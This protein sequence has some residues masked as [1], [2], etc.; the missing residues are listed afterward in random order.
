MN[1]ANGY[2][3]VACQGYDHSLWYAQAPIQGPNSACG[4]TGGLPCFT[5]FTSNSGTFTSGPALVLLNGTLYNYAVG[6][7]HKIWY[8]VWNQPVWYSTGWADGGCVD[9][10]AGCHPAAQSI[11]GGSFGVMAIPSPDGHIWYRV[12]N[13]SGWSAG[14]D[15]G[16]PPA[17]VMDGVGVALG[18]RGEFT[19]YCALYSST[20]GPQAYA[21]HDV[22]TGLAG[23][24]FYGF[25][26]SP[27]T[28]VGAG[29]LGSTEAGINT[30]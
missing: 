9:T 25:S 7:D 6:T 21:V 28:P 23:T 15:L 16:S 19:V 5:N 18:T 10:G 13:G 24:G 11:N 4:G 8:S 14:Y 30:S 26:T 22:W 3:N 29:G 12:W 1:P 20:T 27:A 2:V 17:Q